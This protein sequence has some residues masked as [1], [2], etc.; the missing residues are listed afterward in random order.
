MVGSKFQ[1]SRLLTHLELF[2]LLDKAFLLLPELLGRFLYVCGKSEANSI[3][4]PSMCGRLPQCF[5]FDL[6]YKFLALF[7][8]LYKITCTAVASFA[9]S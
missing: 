6:I 3:A 9:Q 2:P 7:N 8:S 4:N 1:K 5:N